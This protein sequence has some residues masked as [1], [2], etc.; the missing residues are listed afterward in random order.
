[1]TH[2]VCAFIVS[3][4]LITAYIFSSYFFLTHQIQAIDALQYYLLLPNRRLYAISMTALQLCLY[5]QGDIIQRKL[6]LNMG[7]LVGYFSIYKASL[8]IFNQDE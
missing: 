1:M 3:V 6:S 5:N 7:L 4:V 2:Y 8:R